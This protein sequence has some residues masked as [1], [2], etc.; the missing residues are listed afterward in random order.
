MEG[1]EGGGGGGDPRELTLLLFFAK[2][3]STTMHHWISMVLLLGVILLIIMVTKKKTRACR[4]CGDDITNQKRGGFVCRK[5]EC[6]RTSTRNAIEEESIV[7]V[8]T[9][10]PASLGVIGTIDSP[11]GKRDF[12]IPTFSH[13]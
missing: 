3:C 1:G 9:C 11:P 10:E 5:R 12:N 8:E 7:D 6:R 2:S 4:V 13:K